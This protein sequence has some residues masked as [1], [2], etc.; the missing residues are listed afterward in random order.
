MKRLLKIEWLVVKNSKKSSITFFCL[1]LLLT[2]VIAYMYPSFLESF[3]SVAL[4]NADAEDI[5]IAENILLG[6]KQSNDIVGYTYYIAGALKYLLVLFF[7]SY[8]I[9]DYR[10]N[11]IRQNIADGLKKEEYI[12]S[13]FLFIIIS[14]ALL[15][16]I[17]LVLSFLIGIYRNNNF[18]NEISLVSTFGVSFSYFIELITLL[19]FSMVISLCIRKSNV[20]FA[21]I[22]SY[23]LL[24]IYFLSYIM[25]DFMLLLPVNTN[26]FLNAYPVKKYLLEISQFDLYFW[27][28]LGVSIIY[29]YIYIYMSKTILKKQD[30]NVAI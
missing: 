3:F 15:T 24:G 21:L 11:A 13:K 18:F 9:N 1:Y 23:C 14:S 12:F 8:V 30:L 16:G 7:I 5:E 6:N 19:T 2:G 22:I 28:S 25:G 20:V 4:E 17:I 10:L 27:L 26:L 29:I